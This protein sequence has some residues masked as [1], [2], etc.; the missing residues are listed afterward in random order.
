MLNR[1]EISDKDAEVK[2]EKL[3][4]K[5]EKKKLKAPKNTGITE[6]NIEKEIVINRSRTAKFSHNPGKIE[7]SEENKT[8]RII[9]AARLQE[10]KNI[11]VRKER[12]IEKMKRNQTKYNMGQA[13]IDW[14]TPNKK[15][16]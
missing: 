6:I 16:K 3:K 9:E 11:L 2:F 12:E 7:H 13:K 10:A 4:E 5:N 15:F 8:E 14:K 1:K